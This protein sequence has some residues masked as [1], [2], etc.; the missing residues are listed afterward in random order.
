MKLVVVT[1]VGPGHEAVFERAAQ[2][3]HEAVDYGCS[4]FTEVEHFVV[5]D[6][7]GEYGR[8]AA[9]N[10]AIL[11]SPE[12]DWFFF[13]DADDIM[14][15][16]ALEHCTF[17]SAATFGAVYQRGSI[18]RENVWPCDWRS[19]VD[20]GARG[21]L[22]M[23]FFCRADVARRLRFN[24]DLDAGEDFEFYMRLPHFVKVRSPLVEIGRDTPSAVGPRG[25]RSL[26]WI[27]VCNTVIEDAIRCD[28]DKFGIPLT[29]AAS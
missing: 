25:Y 17:N 7:K 16:Y 3:V 6:S 18:I 9:R 8:S 28:P 21:T 5:W 11:N 10:R 4:A 29:S 27:G 14:R 2:S 20:Y 13:L 26:D 22:S 15:P 23:G 19:I 12:A 24:E 1:P